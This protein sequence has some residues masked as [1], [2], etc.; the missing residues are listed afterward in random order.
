MQPAGPHIASLE[1]RLIGKRRR[2]ETDE[3]LNS[4]ECCRAKELEQMRLN[5]YGFYPSGALQLHPRDSDTPTLARHRAKR[6][7]V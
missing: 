4:F 2:R 5:V 1:A 6:A 3:A 7:N